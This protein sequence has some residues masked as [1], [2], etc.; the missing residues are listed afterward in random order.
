MHFK[1]SDDR[2]VMP[3]VLRL[4]QFLGVWDEHGTRYPYKY[5]VVFLCYCFG[6]LIPKVFS[7]YP[8]REATIRS[9]SELILETNV[10]GGMLMFYLRLDYL[11]PLVAEIRSFA[12]IIFRHNQP[13]IVQQ[14]LVQLNLHLHKYT[15]GYCLYMCCV[16]TVYCVTPLWSNFTGYMATTTR[17]NVTSGSSYEFILYHEQDFYWLNNR[18]SLK[19]YCVFTV[20]MFPIMYLCAATGTVKVVAVF[21]TIKYCETMLRVVV[22]KIQHLR[23][24]P[25]VR[26]RADGMSEVRQLHQ[27]ALRCAKLLELTLQPLLLMQ[28]ILCILVWC[29]MMLY[30]TVS[31]FNVKLVNMFLLFLFVSI[32]T[33]GYCYLG[34]QLTHES[35]NVGRALYDFSWYDFDTSMRKHISFMIM[36]SQCRVGLTAAKFCFVDM[37]QFGA[38]LNM[39]YS[40]F[41]V[42]KDVF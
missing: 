18:T 7:S 42:V 10:Y 3:L 5:I 1:P 13:T 39:S 12:A 36:R 34:A 35:F 31:A 24:V 9:Y 26:Q 30:F 17:G 38:M 2:T 4:M 11:K 37:E 41:V 14:N 28:F 22:L 25:D 16:C 15:L 6:I 32:E 33:L 27:R 40:F 19:G 29:S 21:N 23:T 20:V 8:T